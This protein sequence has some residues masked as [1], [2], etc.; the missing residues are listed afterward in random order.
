MEAQKLK[1]NKMIGRKGKIKK[2]I[3]NVLCRP[4]PVK[5]PLINDVERNSLKSV[6]ELYKVHV[7]QYKKPHW[8]EIKLIPK[9]DRPKPSP[10]KRVKG[11]LFGIS[12][13]KNAIADGQCCSV[14]IEANVNPR[15][16]VQPI[17]EKCYSLNIPIL[18]VENLR[19]LSKIYFGIKTSCLCVTNDC[20]TDL[21][22]EIKEI[23]KNYKPN[24]HIKFDKTIDDTEKN[25]RAAQTNGDKKIIEPNIAEPYL[26]R[27]DK[28][29]RVFNPSGGQE[30][31]DINKFCGQ[32]YIKVSDEKMEVDVANETERKAYMRMILKRISNNPNRVRSKQ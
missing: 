27:T 17:I 14:L 25:D 16:I 12:E 26:F 6:L 3:K 19:Q 7:P 21:G 2:T 8:S 22:I 23:F 1:Q 29:T 9:G 18:C 28:K 30:K 10:I 15:T 5:W 13:C 4:D 24:T 31:K 11:L 20:S 32:Q